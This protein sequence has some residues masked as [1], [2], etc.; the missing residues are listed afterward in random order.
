MRF[1][2]DVSGHSK[3]TV[4]WGGVGVGG[5]VAGRELTFTQYLPDQQGPKKD[6]AQNRL[7]ILFHII[8]L[9]TLFK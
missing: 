7:H 4:G 2:S 5:A 3:H 8:F 6:Q 9:I 1:P